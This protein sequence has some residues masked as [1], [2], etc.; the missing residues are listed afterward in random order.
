MPSL[1]SKSVETKNP[2]AIVSGAVHKIK[3]VVTNNTEKED[4]FVSNFRGGTL[5]DLDYD[6]EPSEQFNARI[7]KALDGDTTMGNS[8]DAGNVIPTDTGKK[9]VDRAKKK[10]ASSKTQGTR[11][12][13]NLLDIKT[14]WINYGK[15][16]DS[17][18]LG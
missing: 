6:N 10:E 13:K 16:L 14:Q 5:L 15:N 12:G 8:H 11:D 1:V 2:F 7:K 18:M 17:K 4:E 9:L 3:K